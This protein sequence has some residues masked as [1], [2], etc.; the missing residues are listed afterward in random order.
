MTT[1]NLSQAIEFISTIQGDAPT[2]LLQFF[3]D[4]G[5]QARAIACSNDHSEIKSILENYGNGGYGCFLAV[6]RAHDGATTR[7]KADIAAVN[8]LFADFD[9][10]EPRN[11]DKMPEPSI[12]CQS[13]NGRHYY[14][15]VDETVT[16]DSFKGYQ[17]G[18]AA[19][20]GSDEAVNDYT[21]V[22][23]IPGTLHRKDAANPFLVEMLELHPERRYSLSDFVNVTP[24]LDGKK[25]AAKKTSEATRIE[26][27]I[28]PETYPSDEKFQT[29]YSF[30]GPKG[31]D[32]WH[33]ITSRW[34]LE[35]EKYSLLAEG[36]RN[37][38]LNKLA[39]LSACFTHVEISRTEEFRDPSLVIETLINCGVEMGLSEEEA[40][41]T[42]DSGLTS[43][44]KNQVDFGYWV[45]LANQNPASLKEQIAIVKWLSQREVKYN[46]RCNTFLLDGEPVTMETL[47]NRI[48]WDLGD[49]YDP[50]RFHRIVSERLMGL[51]Y[52]PF[53]GYLDDLK[54]DSSPVKNVLDDAHKQLFGP[55]AT[56]QDRSYLIR[57]LIGAVKRTYEP[58]SKHDTAWILQG[59]QGAFKSTFVGILGLKEDKQTCQHYGMVKPGSSGM[60]IEPFYATLSSTDSG[61]DELMKLIKP[62]IVELEEM[63]G[64]NK[65]EQDVQ[66]EFLSRLADE[67]RPPYGQSVITYPRRCIFI[68]T[69]NDQEF[70]ND[71]TGDR[72]YWVTKVSQPINVK[73]AKANVH[74]MWREAVK[75][76]QAGEPNYLT[77]GE[78][79]LRTQLNREFR[80]VDPY[81]EILLEKIT[82]STT[83]IVPSTLME[84]L[85][86]GKL[87]SGDG[88]RIAKIL[89]ELGFEKT[90]FN[91][92]NGSK[93]TMWVRKATPTKEPQE[94][95][96]VTEEPI[97]AP[98][99][100]TVPPVESKV[101]VSDQDID[102]NRG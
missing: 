17:K 46:F 13:K 15:L 12:V 30:E 3:E 77:P 5:N 1:Q 26:V 49:T 59:G 41:K 96:Q 67:Y 9:K 18:I 47:Q 28:N 97:P 63:A 92:P 25:A 68:G 79:A 44:T 53:K 87:T 4:A 55:D 84:W 64:H 43:G 93:A 38:N 48:E 27:Q 20:T 31:D 36:S 37:T 71:P 6:N 40:T 94:E 54:A 32:L 70:L 60:W 78:E 65:K 95:T 83:S 73:W 89:K 62:V 11:L 16:L 85:N 14:W 91:E 90:R 88:R 102:L 98:K 39:Y 2:I 8:A 57:T 10:T 101:E 56:P 82:N 21:R 80:N 86:L 23:R 24:V 74:E 99:T 75:L 81:E 51:Y 100:P 33:K 22:M 66:K 42:V 76:Y 19:L 35:V 34:K 29:K 52:D 45:K 58:G 61:K 7:K 69:I 72:R 50:Q